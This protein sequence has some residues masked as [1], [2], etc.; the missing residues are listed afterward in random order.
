MDFVIRRGSWNQSHG[1][2]GMAV[3][4]TMNKWEALSHKYLIYETNRTQNLCW[5][6]TFS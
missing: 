5:A 1:Y 2:Q 6:I 4:N 3:I